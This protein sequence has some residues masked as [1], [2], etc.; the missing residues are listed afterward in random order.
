MATHSRKPSIII[1]RYM[2][3]GNAKRQIDRF[4]FL[5][6]F[7]RLVASPLL[8]ARNAKNR[9]VEMQMKKEH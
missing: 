6:R 9:V 3:A 1:C 7:V 5:K 2:Q 8:H 4:T